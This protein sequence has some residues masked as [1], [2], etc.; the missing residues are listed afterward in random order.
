MKVFKNRENFENISAAVKT[1]NYGHMAT[2]A[3]Y[4]LVQTNTMGYFDPIKFWESLDPF[5]GKFKF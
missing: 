2:T 3:A 5:S 4:A 1:E